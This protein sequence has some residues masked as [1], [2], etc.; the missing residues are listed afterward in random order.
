MT[1]KT[2]AIRNRLFRAHEIMHGERNFVSIGWFIETSLDLLASHF[3]DVHLEYM[4][5][6]CWGCSSYRAGD[7]W[8]DWKTGETPEDALA[9]TVIAADKILKGKK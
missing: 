6:D 8:D 2:Q 3:G 9:K 1:N 7:Q 4:N 5:G